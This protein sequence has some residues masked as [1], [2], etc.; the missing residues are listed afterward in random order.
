MAAVIPEAAGAVT[1]G[2]G[3]VRGASAAGRSR[4]SSRAESAVQG[5]PQR[6]RRAGRGLARARVP[7]N[8]NYQ[9]VILAEFL[10]AVLVVALAPIAKGGTD[11]AKTKGGGSPYDTNSLKQILVIGVVY[12]L[13]ALASSGK[14]LGRF[15]AWFGGLV[16]VAIGV[17]QTVDGGFAAV[18]KMF[19]PGSGEGL[20]TFPAGGG[21]SGA[22]PPLDINSSQF[23]PGALAQGV[24]A[25]PGNPT[26][27]FPTIQPGGAVT[28]SLTDSGNMTV[29]R[30]NPPPGGTGT[31]TTGPTA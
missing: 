25:A 8:R 6:G 17:Q 7:G 1:E 16:L 23:S 14:R 24:Q 27:A 4:A 18:I 12:F 2:T 26:D 3:A 20:G 21:P 29:T 5:L 31:T 13:L 22:L 15:S 28:P 11:T 9:P 30:I 10:L 19:L